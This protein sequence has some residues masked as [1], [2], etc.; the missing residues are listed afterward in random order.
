MKRI[1]QAS[2][3]RCDPSPASGSDSVGSHAMAPRFAVLVLENVLA[4]SLLSFSFPTCCQV[5]KGNNGASR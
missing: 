2:A 5:Q 4:I 1:S 3:V